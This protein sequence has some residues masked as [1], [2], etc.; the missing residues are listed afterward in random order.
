VVK[1]NLARFPAPLAYRVVDAVVGG[2]IGTSKIEWLG[3]APE[4]DAGALLARRDDPDERTAMA[5]AVEF[6]KDAGVQQTARPAADILR[7]AVEEG[8]TE[9]TLRRARLRLGIKPWRDEFHGPVSWGPRPGVYLANLSGQPQPPQ[10]GQIDADQVKQPLKPPYLANRKGLGSEV[11]TA[12]FY[13]AAEPCSCGYWTIQVTP[14]LVPIC[15]A[16]GQDAP[17]PVG[18]P[19]VP[20]EPSVIRAG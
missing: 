13:S 16:C 19:Q 18:R 4:V 7:A 9:R 3:E 1:S 5:E 14:G 10:L 2:E 12:G 20:L 11:P 8:I 15:P 6:L 17:S